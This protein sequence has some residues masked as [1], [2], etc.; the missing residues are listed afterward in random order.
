MGKT[1]PKL[2]QPCWEISSIEKAI[3][4][5]AQLDQTRSH[6]FLACHAPIEHIQDDRTKVVL[7]EEEFYSQ[8]MDPSY[9]GVL[10]IVHGDPGTGKSHLI[11]WLKLRCDNAIENG[12]LKDVLPILIQRR[13]GS[14]KDALE[15][16]IHQLPK[17]FEH[18]LTPVREAISNITD[19]TARETLALNLHLEL[20]TKR[21]ERRRA[22]LPRDLQQLAETCTSRG[23]RQW[24]C[25]EGG[26]IDANIKRL[27]R[28]SIVEE[29]EA[30]AI[31]EFTP[32]EFLID[33]R[34]KAD[35]IRDIHV[36]ID[37]FEDE[38]SLRAA[39][40]KLFNEA[41]PD[42]IKEMTGL[43]GARLRDI[44]DRIR[45][46]LKKT[47][48]TLALFI[49][50][51]SVMAALDEEVVNAVEPQSDQNLCRMVAVL[52]MTETGLTRLP[53]NQRERAT[54]I[55][56]VGGSIM[57]EWRRNEE[58]V[59]HFTARYLNAVRLPDGDV[60]RIAQSRRNKGD[61]NISACEECNVRE[62]CHDRFGKVEIAG[63]DIGV[64]PFSKIAPQ[65]LLNSLDEQAEGVRKNP[66]GLLMHV[67]RPILADHSSLEN[68][69]F[70]EAK[71]PVAML[72]LTYWAGF[73]QKFCGDWSKADKS[74]LKFLA[75]GWVEA[76]S[77]E[78]AATALQPFLEPLGF[79]KFTSKVTPAGAPVGTG[80]QTGSS[81]RG[82]SARTG[83]EKDA[84]GR[85]APSPQLE[86]LNEILQNLTR[87]WKEK[88][89]LEG[90]T[91]IRQMLADFIRKS[92]S[93]DDKRFPPLDVW[94]SL[95]GASQYQFVRIKG[96]RSRPAATRF[97]I[98]FDRSEETRDLI[99]ALAQ[100]RYAGIKSWNFPHGEL[101]KRKLSQWL[102]RNQEN[103]IRQLQP[104]GDL[105][106]EEPV[107]FAVQFLAMAAILRRRA[108]LP[109]DLVE[110]VQAIL[111]DRWEELPTALSTEMSQLI[112]DIHNKHREVKEFLLKELNIAQGRTG[113]INFID[114]LIIIK[115]ASKFLEELSVLPPAE[116]YFGDFWQTRYSSLDDMSEFTGLAS[117]L[118]Q[119][120]QAVRERLESVK[121]ILLQAGY[122]VSNLPGALDAYCTDLS[123]L[124]NTQRKAG[125][126]IPDVTF[127]ELWKERVF[128]E[129][130]NAWGR[131]LERAQAD[132][133]AGGAVQ[134]LLFD[135][136]G[137]DEAKVALSVADE[138]TAL[139][140]EQVE[141]K[142]KHIE[143][144]GDPDQLSKSLLGTLQEIAGL[145]EPVNR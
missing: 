122:D 117:I 57:D 119:E 143:Q 65:R 141:E 52:G 71:L 39:A 43:S 37:D 126:Y 70:P 127:D 14:L 90:D 89:D 120:K 66:R 61:V 136:R 93:W 98:D 132:T 106:P 115:T 62:A 86:K 123:E 56:S 94:K 1:I 144:D 18:Y 16:M 58:G 31:P 121:T 49:E 84:K 83:S 138:Y 101:H 13:T 10:A 9:G 96:M 20:N 5:I 15:Q 131:S 74:R 68:E 24:L 34:Y 26:I 8:I 145:L 81:T 91:E 99:E 113:G 105:E 92:I 79:P 44:F 116:G 63:V 21:P 50:D 38:Q 104:R 41:L 107:I 28:E 60:F 75:Q 59:A 29:R 137:L 103:I 77:A 3:S 76:D 110:F 27:T 55:V 4:Q 124:I 45:T 140:E 111:A 36:L 135:P 80:T 139:L 102:R 2:G 22:P 78:M 35:N 51:V 134:V 85:E 53:Q 82:E 46:D 73:E 6:Y 128:S 30:E 95:V 88:K 48:K 17:D 42:A 125:L 47:G 142:L 100:F 109:T 69:T 23:F 114:P 112:A 97:F 129:R 67:L 118:E 130:R 33:D 64:F 40:A 133:D 25:R 108:K 19:R 87:W 72:E 54:H 32:N 11:H 7:T 12:E